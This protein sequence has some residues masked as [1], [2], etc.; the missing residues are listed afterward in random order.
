MKVTLSVSFL[1]DVPREPRTCPGAGA[2]PSVP[3]T[4]RAT[5]VTFRAK[6]VE[7]ST[8]CLMV[9]LS[10]RIAAFTLRDLARKD[11]ARD[12]AVVTSADVADLG[13]EVAPHGVHLSVGPQ[14]PRLPGTFAACRAIRV[15]PVRPRAPLASPRP[16]TIELVHPV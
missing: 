4:P 12:R 1:P 7:L 10:S 15:L 6:G 8:R 11:A 13:G 16:R 2:L 14:V 3:T 9:V 5:R